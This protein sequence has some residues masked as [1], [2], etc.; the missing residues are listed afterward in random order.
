ME[1]GAALFESHA[2]VDPFLKFANSSSQLA[3][4]S[5]TLSYLYNVPAAT[6]CPFDQTRRDWL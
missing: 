1:E 3:K 4:R 6:G 5:V 2:R